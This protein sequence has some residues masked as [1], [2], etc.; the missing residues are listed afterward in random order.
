M[1][2]NKVFV[3]RR[4]DGLTAPCDA[5]YFVSC[6]AFAGEEQVISYNNLRGARRFDSEAAARAALEN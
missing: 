6:G 5:N 1:Y 2:P 4:N 3:I